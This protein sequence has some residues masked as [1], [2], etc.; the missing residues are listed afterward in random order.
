MPEC[1]NCG[2]HVTERYV[3]VFTPD[4]VDAA[5]VCPNCEDM[6]RGADGP[7]EVRHK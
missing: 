5:R 1:R 6:T 2:S 4:G 3:R 7:R